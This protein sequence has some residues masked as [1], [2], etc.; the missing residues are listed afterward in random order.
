MLAQFVSQIAWAAS[1]ERRGS[2]IVCTTGI[3]DY[4]EGGGCGGMCTR[5]V[6]GVMPGLDE[7]GK[8]AQQDLWT[9]NE[10]DVDRTSLCSC[11]V[12]LA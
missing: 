8:W 5:S 12:S 7:V 10:E 1:S 3:L 6:V 9:E 11:V 2:V 4:M